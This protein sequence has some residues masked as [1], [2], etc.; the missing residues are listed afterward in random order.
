MSSLD[1]HLKRIAIASKF[2]SLQK[3]YT[4]FLNEVSP[5]Q[6]RGAG[7]IAAQLNDAAIKIQTFVQ[8]TDTEKEIDWVKKQLKK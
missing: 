5:N 2:K 6:W 1:F 3:E 4:E 7:E 8:I